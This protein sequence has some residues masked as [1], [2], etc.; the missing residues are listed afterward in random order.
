MILSKEIIK[1]N[2]RNKTFSVINSLH[3]NLF[4]GETKRGFFIWELL[5]NKNS[6]NLYFPSRQ[7]NIASPVPGCPCSGK[8]PSLRVNATKCAVGPHNWFHRGEPTTEMLLWRA[9]ICFNET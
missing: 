6:H 9:R 8:I 2:W 7:Q 3:K 1:M 4:L 5:I